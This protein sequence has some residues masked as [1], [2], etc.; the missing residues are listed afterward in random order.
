VSEPSST[1]PST[2]PTT[3]TTSTSAPSFEQSTR[4]L[5]QIVTELEG[6][7]LPLERSLA[8]FEEGVRLARAAQEELDRAERRVDELL[9]I[10]S[11]GKPVL[12]DATSRV[13]GRDSSRDGAP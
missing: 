11:K 13:A 4:R 5:Q 7:D 8:L 6:G 2:A 3:S 1:A 10:D 12:R 9:G